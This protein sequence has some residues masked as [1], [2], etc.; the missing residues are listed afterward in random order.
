MIKG[1]GTEE[2]NERLKEICIINRVMKTNLICYLS[3]VYFVYQPLHVSGI[4]VAHH[5]EVCCIY[6]AV[7]K[8]CAVRLS[9]CWPAGLW[10]VVV[11]LI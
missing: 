3:S 7:G 1:G 11:C 10:C 5:Q 6:R 2:D 8:C 4:F 9:V